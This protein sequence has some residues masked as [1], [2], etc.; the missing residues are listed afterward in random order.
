MSRPIC[1]RCSEVIVI[2]DLRNGHNAECKFVWRDKS[3]SLLTCAQILDLKH[4]VEESIQRDRI[5]T[6]RVTA[7]ALEDSITEMVY[8]Q[9]DLDDSLSGTMD[10][11]EIW[12][13]LENGDTWRVHLCVFA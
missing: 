6:V 5:V 9:H 8:W 3:I 1:E 13:T 2:G 11:A 10:G 4:A 7:D 12:G